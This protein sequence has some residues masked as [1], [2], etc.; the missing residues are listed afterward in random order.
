MAERSPA[1]V[2]T[3][4]SPEMQ[5]L[6]SA[7]FNPLWKQRPTTTEGWKSIVDSTAAA[8]TARLPGL[9][10][11][12]RV[13]FERTTVGGARAFAVTPQVVAPRNENRLLIHIHGGCYVLHPGEAGLPEAIFMAAFGGFRVLSIDYRMP[14]EAFFPAALDD[15]VSVWQAT[16]ETTGA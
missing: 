9:C 10:D 14:P 11:R 12:L 3:T 2:P 6:I 16:A 5:A 15:C 4:V 13:R 1:P 7:P 8:A